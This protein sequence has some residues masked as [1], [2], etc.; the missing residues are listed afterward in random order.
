M[1]VFDAEF[2][3]AVF[4][5]KVGV[6]DVFKHR[7]DGEDIYQE[8]LLDDPGSATVWLGVDAFDSTGIVKDLQSIY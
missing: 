5:L 3:V 8:V 1:F 6:A 2:A 7:A 4:K